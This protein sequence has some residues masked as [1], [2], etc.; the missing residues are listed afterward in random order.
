MHRVQRKPNN[1]PRRQFQPQ[2]PSF[3]RSG[4]IPN[5]PTL[6]CQREIRAGKIKT[7]AT[8]Y[9]QQT[10]NVQ[11]QQRIQSDT[12][13]RI[14]ADGLLFRPLLWILGRDSDSYEQEPNIPTTKYGF[15]PWPQLHPSTTTCA[16]RS[17]QDCIKLCATPFF[18]FT[19][20]FGTW[21]APQYT[22]NS[23]FQSGLMPIWWRWT[24]MN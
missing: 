20:N 7:A 19:D 15:S 9:H 16:C 4:A 23:W 2:Q 22:S 21:K 14:Q 6:D 3:V 18:F 24:R 10:T 5:R 13:R 11:S 8:D 1:S 17:A 12:T